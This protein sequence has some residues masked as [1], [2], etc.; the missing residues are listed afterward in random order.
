MSPA[1]PDL[2][3]GTLVAKMK[4]TSKPKCRVGAGVSVSRYNPDG[5]DSWSTYRSRFGKAR[6]ASLAN[7]GDFLSMYFAGTECR[8]DS[9]VKAAATIDGVDVGSAWITLRSGYGYISGEI[10]TTTP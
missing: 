1:D 3:S 2:P 10:P 9:K 5:E 8:D 6:A 4:T 7:P